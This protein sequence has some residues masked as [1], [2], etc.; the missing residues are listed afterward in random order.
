MTD[1]APSP[2][3]APLDPGF[4]DSGPLDSAPRHLLADHRL[5]LM[6]A[7]GFFSGLPLPLSGFTFRLWLSEGGVSLALIGLT[8]N[9]GL[10]YSL[11]F[12]WAPVLDQARPPGPLGRLGRRRGWL[13]AIQPALALAA[14]LLALSHPNTAPAGAIAAAGLVA[15]LSASQ[16]IVIDAWRIETFP[17]RAQ[18]AA[19]AAY[20]WGYRVALLVSGA[21][22]IASAS[23]VG[24]HGAL[25]AMAALLALGP[26]VTLLA[27]EP[28]VRVRA[29]GLRLG[30]RL[31]AAVIEPLREMLARPGAPTILGFVALFKLGEAM[32]GVMTAPFYTHLGFNRAAIAV[33]NGPLSLACA[34]G[35]TALGG[36]LVARIGVGRALLATGWVQ[37]IDDGDVSAARGFGRAGACAG[38]D[39][40]GGILRR[41]HGG[42][43]L[44]HLPLRPLLARLHGDAVRAAIFPGGDRAAHGGRAVGVPGRGDWMDVVLCAGDVCRPAGDGADAAAAATLPAG[45]APRGQPRPLNCAGTTRSSAA[46]GLGVAAGPAL[47]PRSI[48]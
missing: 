6:G 5:W 31:R 9:V 30:A 13:A 47:S 3:P 41:G 39:G 34:L 27:P 14:L 35:G 10:A 42:R 44:H 11:K 28:M 18:G 46:R 15:F 20:V 26:L 25:A 21:G 36:W 32:A 29:A 38:R 33:A 19:M 48:P 40:R 23:W 2:D 1:A 16:D 4:L 17:P 8:A 22:V 45:G 12:L 43:G 37:T 7:Y 24:W